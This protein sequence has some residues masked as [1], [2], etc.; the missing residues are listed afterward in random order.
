[1]GPILYGDFETRSVVDI[2]SRGLHNYATSASTEVI[3]LGYAFDDEDPNLWWAGEAA[4]NRVVDHIAR[5]GKFV[6][7][8]APFELAIWNNIMVRVHGW[9]AL[10]AEQTICTAARSYAMGLPGSLEN[11]A[12][13]LDV[14]DG[15]DKTGHA[16]MLRLCAPINKKAVD[17]GAAPKWAIDQ[18]TFTFMGQKVTPEWAIKRLGEYCKKDVDVERWIMK[19][20]RA[21]STTEQKVWVLDQK[22]NQRGVLFD[23][24]AI[25]GALTLR[26]TTL[27]GLDKRMHDVTGGA[28]GACSALP[29]LKEW[30]AGLGV[31]VGSAA[32][33][34]LKELLA[35]DLPAPVREAL[36]LRSAAGRATSATK[37]AK[38]KMLAGDDGRVRNLVQYHGA[39]TGRWAG[40]GLQTHNFPRDLPKPKVA[41]FIMKLITEADGRAIGMFFDNPLTALSKMLRAFL[42]AEDGKS[43]IGGDWANVEGRGLP[44]LAGEEWKLDAFKAV[45]SDPGAPDVY[46]VTYAESF[47]IDPT[48]VTGDQR[49]IGKVMELAFG[50]QGGVGAFH[51]MGASYGVVVEDEVADAWKVAWRAKHPKVVEYWAALQGA[52]SSATQWPGETF[53]AG[54][55][56]RQVKF[57]KAGSFLWCLLPTGRVLCYPYPMIRSV[58]APWSRKARRED[59]NLEPDYI[60]VVTYK[61]VPS[62]DSWKKG[63]IVPDPTNTRYWARVSTYGGKLAENITQAVCR[64]ILADAMLRLDAAGHNIVLH[65]HDEVIVEGLYSEADRAIFQAVLQT[66]PEWARDLPLAADCWINTR[67]QK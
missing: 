44:W 18:K 3:C 58:E 60:K 21:L 38:A 15:K 31:P 57:R 50:Y 63:A 33:E 5:G 37:L 62:P 30:C 53:T 45:D 64:D 24:D 55:K 48:A 25:V 22:I 66:P 32:K 6:A 4:P 43:F 16:L 12:I 59:P 52:A 41:E 47:G 27:Q 2:R 29:A 36:T 1:M 14:S 13:A 42:K 49:Q 39:G 8:N 26:D 34:A 28:V 11:A 61:T 35:G 40:R 67:Y 51:Q 65:I 9:P 17:E 23:P 7:H 19:R 56:H 10:R 46:E 20:T 54:P